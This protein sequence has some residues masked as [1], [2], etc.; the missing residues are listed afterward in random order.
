MS[1]VKTQTQTTIKKSGDKVTVIKKITTTTT[2]PGKV[3][4]K[5][6]STLFVKRQDLRAGFGIL[7]T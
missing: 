2:K 4:R 1:S 3:G 6:I 7:G 5:E